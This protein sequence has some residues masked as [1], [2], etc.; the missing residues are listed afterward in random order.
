MYWLAKL[1]TR[2]SLFKLHSQFDVTFF[3]T[4]RFV[5]SCSSSSFFSSYAYDRNTAREKK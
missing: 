1:I 5:L 3:S 2:F 4:L